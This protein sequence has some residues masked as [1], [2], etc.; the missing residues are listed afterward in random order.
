MAPYSFI[1]S[2]HQVFLEMLLNL[3][4]VKKLIL[5]KKRTVL[6]FPL[7]IGLK[8]NVE[9][10][11]FLIKRRYPCYDYGGITNFQLNYKLISTSATLNTSLGKFKHCLLIQG[12]G[13]TTFIRENEVG[14][15][16]INILSQEW[17]AKGIGL[18]KSIRTEQTDTE[19]FGTTR[20][21]QSFVYYKI[22]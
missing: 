16:E 10:K 18:V 2:C 15:I 11:T 8:W 7:K 14:T 1:I 3:Q 13:K 12:K 22:K 19:L 21:V 4:I 5:K 9:S 17:Y 6:P 20:M